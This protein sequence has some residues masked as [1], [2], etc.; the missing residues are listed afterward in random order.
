L[1]FIVAKGGAGSIA[2][3][4][5]KQQYQGNGNIIRPINKCPTFG[6]I[7]NQLLH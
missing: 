3:S 7:A 2:K 5:K 4:L 6:A 1:F